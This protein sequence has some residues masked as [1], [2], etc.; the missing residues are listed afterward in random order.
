MFTGFAQRSWT[1]FSLFASLAFVSVSNAQVSTDPVISN[2]EVTT[3]DDAVLRQIAEKYEIHRRD[4]N[5][6]QVNVPARAAADFKRIAPNARLL[7]ADIRDALRAVDA[8]PEMRAGYHTFAQVQDILK[9]IA[10]DYPQ[11][12]KLEEYG[13]SKAGRPLVALKISDN[14]DQDE[15]EPEIML[16]AATHGD[17][18]ITVEVLLGILD[19]MVAGYSNDR[20]LRSLIDNREVY[21]IPVVNADGFATKNR[22]DN[23]ADPNRSYPWPGNTQGSPTPSIRP[24]MDFFM[25]HNF[26]ASIDFHASGNLVMYPWAYTSEAIGGDIAA[27]FKDV[28]KKMSDLNGYRAGQISKILYVAKGSSADYY[29]WK[30]GTAAMAIEM[31]NTKVPAVGQIA[32]VLEDNLESTFAFL[33]HF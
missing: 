28:A 15:D 16:T 9:K 24:L 27:T 29:L 4:G 8:D 10:A 23:G 31:A 22:Y 12:A 26:V 33:E 30:K 32:S 18:L 2:Y 25:K 20:R 14:V 19:K 21:F 1:V 13:K 6:F 11:I 17:E 3:D 7:E 5:R